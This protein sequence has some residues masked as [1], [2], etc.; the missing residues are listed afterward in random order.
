MKSRTIRCASIFCLTVACLLAGNGCSLGVML[1]KMLI[2]DPMI[3]DDFKTFTGKSLS[4]EGRKVAVLCT[5]P[6]S[7]KDNY[8]SLQIELLRDVSRKMSIHEIDVIKPHLVARWIDDNGGETNDLGALAREVDAD[9]IVD[10]NVAQFSYREENSPNLFRGRCN[11]QVTVFEFKRDASKKPSGIPGKV[12]EKGFQ[13]VH[14]THQPVPADQTSELIF[15]KKFMDRVGDQI[16]RLFYKHRA[17][18][19]F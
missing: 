8:A 17:G 14:P 4:E 16:A 15:R 2:G 11:G 12:Y 6:E 5:A 1:G 7:I 18:V 13:S 3:G 19:E 10:I 9:F